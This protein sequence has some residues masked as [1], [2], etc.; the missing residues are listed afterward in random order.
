M[1]R[2]T[3]QTFYIARPPRSP[4][5]ANLGFSKGVGT[6]SLGDGGIGSWCMC[7]GHAIYRR[8]LGASYRG[9]G[10]ILSPLDGGHPWSR[11]GAGGQWGTG[12]R[13]PDRLSSFLDPCLS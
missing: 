4:K 6:D 9:E 11:T 12:G 8:Y 10:W 3:R 2:L 7:F 1:P 13:W 5:V